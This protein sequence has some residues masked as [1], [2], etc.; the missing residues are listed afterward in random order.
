[1]YCPRLY[2]CFNKA[3][4]ITVKCLSV[5]IS[6]TKKNN[7]RLVFKALNDH[8]VGFDLWQDFNIV[9]VDLRIFVTKRLSSRMYYIIKYY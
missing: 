6:D 8:T 7:R 5:F 2:N 4:P 1:M 9:T 3:Q